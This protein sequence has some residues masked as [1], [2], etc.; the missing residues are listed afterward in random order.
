MKWILLA[1]IVSCNAGGD[2]LNT[3]GMKRH[4]EVEDFGARH[5]MHVAARSLR[6]PYVLG[7]ILMLA[8]SFFALL[9][10]LSISSVSFAVP[11]TAIGY[12]LETLL[13]KVV[14]KEQVHWRR[15]AGAGMVACGV[16]LIS[17]Q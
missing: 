5:M 12:L 10:L 8:G 11:A 13:S 4:G 14:L 16:V 3:M 1:I 17:L 15:W 6:S 9:G 7:G 2:V